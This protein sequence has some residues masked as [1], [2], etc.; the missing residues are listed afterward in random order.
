MR[1]DDLIRQARAAL[2]DLSDLAPKAPSLQSITAGYA[3][4]RRIESP[5]TRWR[6]V[7]VLLAA[8]AVTLLVV[9][10]ASLIGSN[11]GD[12]DGVTGPGVASRADGDPL[13]GT[14]VLTSYTFEGETRI[15][16][17]QALATRNRV[18]AWIEITAAGFLGYTGCNTIAP[19]PR[20]VLDGG[21][22][23][24]GEIVVT[25]AGCLDETPEPAVLAALWSGPDGIIVSI[26]GDTM[27]WATG[28][29]TLTFERRDRRPSP[30]P[31][32]WPSGFGRLDC[33]PGV[34]LTETLP[35]AAQTLADTLM[36]IPGVV[37]VEEG[38][39]FL[40]GLDGTGT[41]IAAAAYG[42]VEPRVIHRSACASSFG[43]RPD[44]DLTGATMTWVNDLGLA[45]TSPLVW[46]E[47]FVE[48]CSPADPDV[49]DLSGRYLEED[50][51][52]SVRGD[53]SLPTVEQAAQ[54]L[55]LMRRSVCAG[56]RPRT[57]TTVPPG[58]DGGAATTTTIVT[59]SGTPGIGNQPE[60][61][62]E[63]VSPSWVTVDDED[64]GGILQRVLDGGELPQVSD[65]IVA[66]VLGNLPP[67]GWTPYLYRAEMAGEVP[68]SEDVDVYLGNHDSLS[69]T[70]YYLWDDTPGCDVCEAN[71]VLWDNGWMVWTDAEP[72][73]GVIQY[74][75]SHPD[76][77]VNARI[78]FFP[79]PIEWPEAWP[80]DDPV[81]RTS[82]DEADA[83]TASILDS[84]A[85]VLP[86]P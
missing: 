34:Y 52:T 55:D 1:D 48:L 9:G 54:T 81:L 16:D 6:P 13:E 79:D 19:S 83:I 14:W 74:H 12:S 4:L 51:A 75:A 26:D 85:E 42:D 43:V 30:Q 36:G 35:D 76:F 29:A 66:A 17:E 11:V 32:A 37:S 49:V 46:G 5:L 64:P 23:V 25:A 44:T 78:V 27:T 65:T 39:P 77:P 24:F 22:L 10:V 45:Q 72:D 28:T 21:R 62:E 7:V 70:W 84:L 8:A 33:S 80:D 68:M 38:E 3:P 59:S 2:D 50:A 15:L 20:P 73:R 47:R 57:T 82:P 60:I 69:V 53:G 71:A 18:P 58:T 86:A 56:D 61:T 40:W 67:D 63:L 41:V 31:G